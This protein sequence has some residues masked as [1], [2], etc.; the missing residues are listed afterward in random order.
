MV[1]RLSSQEGGSTTRSTMACSAV[2][3]AEVAA[4]GDAAGA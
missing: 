3:A 1:L 2:P 4:A